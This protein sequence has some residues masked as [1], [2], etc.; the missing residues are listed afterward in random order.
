MWYELWDSETGNRVGKYPTED[1][2]LRAVLED[3]RRYGRDARAIVSLGLLQ[4]D[5]DR[6]QGRLIAE[7]TALVERALAWATM[8]AL[9]GWPGR[10]S[11]QRSPAACLIAY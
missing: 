8:D 6:Q 7:G 1:A 10:P 5:P 2:A 11:P 4:R 3:I 9:T